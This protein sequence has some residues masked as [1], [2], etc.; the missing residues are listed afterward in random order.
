MVLALPRSMGWLPF[1][2][3]LLSILGLVDS[4]YQTYTHFTNTGLLGCS[5]ASDPCVAVQS[6]Q[7]A[8]V[9]GIPVAVL[10][11]IFYVF[12]VAI[13]SPFAW[14]AESPLIHRLRF[15][16]AIAGMLFVLYL[17]YTE[18]VRIGRIC[19]YCTSV[20]II[21]FVIFVLIMYY[22]PRIRRLAPASP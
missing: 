11:L 13:C 10:G 16:A 7:Y 4:G 18:I 2:T 17:I 12:M 21:T 15:V 8:W 14:R 6:S 3:F 22:G 9:F 19:P 5:A 1:A 20:H